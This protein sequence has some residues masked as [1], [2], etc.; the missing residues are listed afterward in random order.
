MTKRWVSDVAMH[1]N[2]C[3]KVFVS[4]FAHEVTSV[5]SCGRAQAWKYTNTLMRAVCDECNDMDLPDPMHKLCIV[6][7]QKT[8]HPCENYM[9][10]MHM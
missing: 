8:S 5:G 3:L 6:Y 4:V 2:V 10:S 7:R 1:T 9:C